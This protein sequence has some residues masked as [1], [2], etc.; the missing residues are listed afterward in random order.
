MTGATA[1]LILARCDELAT[2]TVLPGGLIERVYLSA[3]HAA[4]NSLAARWM[5]EAGL[6]IWQDAAGNQCGRREGA[7]PGLPALLLGS[8]LDT[9]PSAGRYDGIL[10]VLL[11]IAVADR[12]RA[13]GRRL[14][15]ALEVVAFGDEEGTRFGTTLLGSRAFSGTWQPEWWNLSDAD[16]VTVH[17]AFLAFGLDPDRVGE[18]ARSTRDLVGYLEAHIEQ[19]P[20]LDDADEPLGV[21]TSIA[22]ARRFQI[23]IEGA[24]GHSGTS[25]SLRRDALAGASEAILAIEDIARTANLIATVGHLQV[26]P[27]AVNV[28]AGRAEFSLDLRGESDAA[29]DAVWDRIETALADICSRRQLDVHT[30]QTHVAPA[31]HCSAPLRAVLDRGIRSTRTAAAAPT[32]VPS[33]FSMA[34]HDAMAVAAVT[35]VAMLFVRCAGGVSH[36]PDESVT[37]A[38]VAVALD[39]LEAAVLALADGYATA[40]GSA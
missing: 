29:R 9:V 3:Q 20:V 31:A 22:G 21:V 19:G 7:V 15:F 17:E 24:A 30:V 4:V 1:A 12:I 6:S 8:H 36:H 38:D 32:D 10:G 16:G 13:S 39:A 37:A 2:H 25:W 35:D 14:P 26:F 23:T 27:D 28:I 18:A 34:G 5:T 11:A 33:L 40:G